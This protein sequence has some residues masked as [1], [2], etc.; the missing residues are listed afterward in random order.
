[1]A[2]N[3]R[4]LT[5]FGQK[6]LH[7]AGKLLIALAE[8]NETEYLG[9][10]VAVEFNP[11]SGNVFLV[12]EDFNVAMLTDDG[13]LEDWFSSPY[14]GEEGFYSDLVEMRDDLNEE[15]QEW[16]DEITAQRE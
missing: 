6:E 14:E 2:D 7:D 12:D 1:M 5:E 10:G 9:D 16:L 3:T 4:D 8:A 15:D 13:K 11:Q